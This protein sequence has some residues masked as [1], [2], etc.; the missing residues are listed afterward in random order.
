M[1]G[2]RYLERLVETYLAELARQGGDQSTRGLVGAL[3]LGEIEA[4]GRALIAAG[5]LSNER[6]R[7]VL[8]DVK[9]LLI[10]RGIIEEVSGAVSF[11]T[12][13]VVAIGDADAPPA[14]AEW[15]RALEPDRAPE[16]VRV[17]PILKKLELNDGDSVMLISLEM[18]SDRFGLRYATSDRP[19]RGERGL[20]GMRHF[21]WD[22]SDDAG[23]P[24]RRGGGGGG[25][26]RPWFLFTD[27]FFPAP[28]SEATRLDLAARSFQE[29]RELFRTRVGLG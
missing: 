2:G 22:I 8:A 1:D 23:T 14:P 18:W 5:V 16:L 7:A 13:E 19:A 6:L 24:Y 17:V 26:G 10:E 21:M 9:H 27:D 28:P 3:R 25:G 15:E 11:E 20:P 12:G 29:D 4:A